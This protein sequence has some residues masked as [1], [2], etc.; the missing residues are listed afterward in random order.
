MGQGGVGV[1]VRV[2][3]AAVCACALYCGPL[4]RAVFVCPHPHLRTGTHATHM[5]CLLSASL[6]LLLVMPFAVLLLSAIAA[7]VGRDRV[8]LFFSSAIM[9]GPWHRSNTTLTISRPDEPPAGPGRG[10]RAQD[11]CV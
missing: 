4:P 2:V 5:A 6:C 1:V 10:T 3:V 7:G 9:P 11:L 8:C